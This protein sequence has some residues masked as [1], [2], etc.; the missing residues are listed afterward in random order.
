MVAT[1][2]V[3]LLNVQILLFFT[4][5]FQCSVNYV[6]LSY[7]QQNSVSKQKELEGLKWQGLDTENWS[8]YCYPFTFI[9]N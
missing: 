5:D 4:I 2:T 6:S 9:P 7:G 1:L 3:N 8:V